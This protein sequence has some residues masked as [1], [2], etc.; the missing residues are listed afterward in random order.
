MKILM[1]VFTLLL[2]TGLIMLA[3]SSPATA[4]CSDGVC[5][6]PETAT[7]QLSDDS[8]VEVSWYQ[9][10]QPTTAYSRITIIGDGYSISIE[11]APDE[12]EAASMT[13]TNGD[14][15]SAWGEGIIS[16]WTGYLGYPDSEPSP[17]DF[18]VLPPELRGLWQT[19]RN[20]CGELIEDNE[21]WGILKDQDQETLDSLRADMES[22]RDGLTPPQYFDQIFSVEPSLGHWY[23]ENGSSRGYRFSGPVDLGIT[24]PSP[25]GDPNPE[26]WLDIATSLPN[27]RWN[28]KIIPDAGRCEVWM[29]NVEAV[30]PLTREDWEPWLE[31]I[32]QTL[33]FWQT[34]LPF[35]REIGILEP[36]DDLDLLLEKSIEGINTYPIELTYPHEWSEAIL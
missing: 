23:P 9:T 12:D 32:R 29:D 20:V 19:L 30:Q 11:Y 36:N 21:F 27:D 10:T 34:Q 22:M 24:T 16:L 14:A 17:V 13:I 5:T 31:R 2:A 33:V 18:D 4:Q 1:R 8:T 6:L 35:F 28:L 7:L 15:P 26:I 3:D 25:Y